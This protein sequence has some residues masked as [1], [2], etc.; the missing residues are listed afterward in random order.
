MFEKLTPGQ[1]IETTIV[2]ISGD[3]IFIDLN[4]KSEGVISSAEF[5]DADGN[6]SVKAGDKIKAFS[7]VNPQ[8]IQCLKTHSKI[9]F[10]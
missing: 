10:L 7:Q 1:E 5:A 2:Q 9:I 8:T 6:I 3:T 4:A